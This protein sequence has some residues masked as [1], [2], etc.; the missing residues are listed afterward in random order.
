MGEFT[1]KR[2]GKKGIKAEILV[3]GKHKL[4][5]TTAVIIMKQ[6]LDIQTKFIVNKLDF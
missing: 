3:D 5:F 6:L 1:S 2:Y 4:L